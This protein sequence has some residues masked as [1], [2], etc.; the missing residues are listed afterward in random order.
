MLETSV[1]F[2]FELEKVICTDI[3]LRNHKNSLTVQEIRVY[4]TRNVGSVSLIGQLLRNHVYTF[5]LLSVHC[6]IKWKKY[7]LWIRYTYTCNAT[8]LKA[9]YY[10]L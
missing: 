10:L 9:I 3:S 6:S 7:I 2:E 8:Y 4:L 5:Y 1:E